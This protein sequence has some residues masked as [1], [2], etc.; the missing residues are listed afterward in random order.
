[1]YQL[2]EVISTDPAFA[3]ELLTIANSPL[4][5]P[6]IPAR[7]V[8]EAIYRLGTRHIQGLCLTVASRTYLGRAL[9]LPAMKRMWNHNL[10]TALIAE[11][12]AIVFRMNKD[13]AYTG[14][15]MHEIGRL[16]MAAIKPQ[17]YA[18]LLST[19]VGTADSILDAE[20]ALFGFDHCEA[21]MNMVESWNL[22]DHF[23]AM[24]A[25]AHGQVDRTQP[26]EMADLVH[27]SCQMATT[28]GFSAF[29]GCEIVAFADLLAELPEWEA[30]HFHADVESLTTDVGDRI[31]SVQAL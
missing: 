18:A 7:S 8:L 22:P 16:A 6:R 29:P 17:E 15:V 14:G 3:S 27:L 2:S 5:A 21:G 19:F 23:D 9:N 25:R 30:S 31:A 24:V 13:D 20:R 1:M 26:W 10:A 4:Y 12:L 28:V 11:Q